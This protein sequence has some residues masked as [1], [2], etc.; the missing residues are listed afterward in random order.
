MRQTLI[1]RHTFVIG[2][3]LNIS[4]TSGF[5]LCFPGHERVCKW[6]IRSVT[7]RAVEENLEHKRWHS[8]LTFLRHRPPKDFHTGSDKVSPG[9]SHT[10]LTPARSR[11]A[12]L[13]SRP[14]RRWCVHFSSPIER[15]EV[16]T[17]AKYPGLLVFR[18]LKLLLHSQYQTSRARVDISVT[19]LLPAP[20][21]CD[22]HQVHCSING[23]G[24]SVLP[25]L[26]ACA[27]AAGRWRQT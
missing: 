7:Q 16:G 22:I 1:V 15:I 8:F 12:V 10:F 3:S 24:F 27:H 9:L 6:K 2:L 18:F 25:F 20:L 4:P 19:R 17:F 13:P 14:R 23:T 21:L 11:R 5:S 26:P